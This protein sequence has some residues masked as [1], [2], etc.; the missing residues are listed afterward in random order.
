MRIAQAGPGPPDGI[1]HGLDRL[2]LADDPLVEALLHVDELGHL[3]FEEL[4]DRD[5]RPRGHDLG[6]VVRVDLLLEQAT[7]TVEGGDRRLLLAESLLE[8]DQG[9][10]LELGCAAVVGLAL[11]LLDPRLERLELRLG[12]PGS[13]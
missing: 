12:R 8:L 4:G 5:P 3:A 1:R 11:D 7:R 10:V 6:D 13:R 2:V 9:A